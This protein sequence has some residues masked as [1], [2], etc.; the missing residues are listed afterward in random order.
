MGALRLFVF[1]VCY[2]VLVRAQDASFVEGEVLVKFRPQS[3]G[4][5]LN[6]ADFVVKKKLRTGSQG[7]RGELALVSAPG[8]STAQLVDELRRNPAV[9]IAQPNYIRRIAARLPG[10]DPRFKDVWAL[11]NTGQLVNVTSGT[12]GADIKWVAAMRLLQ[13]TGE[14]VVAV[15]D[16][17]VAY[18]HEELRNRVWTNAG[19]NP[20]NGIDDDANGYVDDV[21]GYDF[22]S[23]ATGPDDDAYSHGTQAAG[24]IAAEWDNAAGIV[25]V[26]QQA[27]IMA[28]R[29]FD[30][31][32]G[33]TDAQLIEAIDYAVMMKTSGVPVVA[34]NAS[35]G[36]YD[37]ATLIGLALAEAGD[38]GIVVC[39]GAGNDAINNDAQPFNP[40]SL[41]LSNIVAVGAS[42]QLDA[43]WAFSNYGVTTV[44]LF[45]PG[46][47]N[48]GLVP[49]GAGVVFTSHL[50]KANAAVYS[51]S[52]PGT[53]GIVY[54]CGLGFA[55]SFP[56]AVSGNI[57]LVKLGTVPVTTKVANAVSA[58]AVAV[59]IYNSVSG[60]FTTFLPFTGSWPP[61]VT[62]SL[63]DGLS[64]LALLPVQ[65]VVIVNGR[66]DYELGLSN[67]TSW[68]APHVAGAVA[69]M[70]LAF[71]HDHVTQRIARVLTGVEVLPAFTNR[72]VTGGRL[73]LARMLDT[74]TDGIGDWWEQLYASNLIAMT[75]TTD[76]DGDG[77]SDAQEFF[78]GTE[79]L[80]SDSQL[81]I[82]AIET[83]GTNLV[84]HWP[85]APARLYN[86][87]T[88][89]SL[90]NSFTNILYSIPATLP[91]VI[92]T[93][94]PNLPA[95]FHRIE[96]DW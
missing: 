78:A 93:N 32:G 49:R 75:S 55:T 40:A 72:C 89:S 87:Q 95:A 86:L 77:A 74:D 52:T 27:R 73:D 83:A 79:P 45:A 12:P 20:T 85:G 28:L 90:T 61:T 50:H 39:A 69:H 3:A 25:G 44:D 37:D 88:A 23:A 19:E 30:G 2:A 4:A 53:T 64:L 84:L 71:P 46:V 43:Q 13:P 14:V 29:V 6:A 9:E 1:L 57:A 59:V 18:Y 81:R 60:N 10:N 91:H 34:I 16:T 31:A 96:L 70:A 26:C 62:L 65:A 8:R 63:E 48:I 38:A 5:R 41:T 94:V 67:G 24:I 66:V 68:A 58:G 36:S 42:D 51:P 22:S 11:W 54:D 82:T 21:H 56:A 47:N 76:T 80:D 17:G 35:W 92:L 15:I 7:G 33:A